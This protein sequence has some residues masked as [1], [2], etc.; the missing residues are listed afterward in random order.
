MKKVKIGVVA[1]YNPF[2]NGHIYQLN[3]IKKQFPNSRI[4][5]AMSYRYSQRGEFICMSWNKRKKYAKKYGANKFIKLKMNISSQ[6][7]HIFARESVLK[8]AKKGINYLVFGSEIGDATYLVNIATILKNNN[9]QYNQLVK[10]YLKQK[11]LSFPRATNLALQELTNEDI[12]MPN[13]IL[14]IEYIKTIVNENLNI[15]PI[16]LKRTIDFHAQETVNNF[17]SATKLREMIK[18]KQDISKY[19][20]V[21]ISDIKFK[22]I[23]STYQRFQKII[24]KTPAKEIAKYKMISEGMENLFKKQINSPD[25]E[26]FI[27][28]CTSKRY[29]SAR[30]KRAYLFVLHKIK[31]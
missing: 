23:A 13:D 11:G 24:S 15:V 30:I 5:V 6:A 14:G 29:T 16:A 18:S 20:P 8:L 3:W 22:D 21:K 28:N 10:K 31:K 1:E 25:Y 19:T 9:A 12:S 27:K 2:H 26:S 4:Y 17:A 7:A